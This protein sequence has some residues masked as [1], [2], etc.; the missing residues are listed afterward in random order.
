MPPHV[1][2]DCSVT[3]DITSL[4]LKIEKATVSV[5]YGGQSCVTYS[6]CSSLELDTAEPD[7]GRSND[8]IDD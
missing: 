6:D 7:R 8:V 3:S 5:V 1:S 2:C 4:V